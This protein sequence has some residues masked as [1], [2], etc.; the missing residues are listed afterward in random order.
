MARVVW[1]T[2]VLLAMFLIIA[3]AVIVFTDP[4]PST[5]QVEAYGPLEI[6][7]CPLHVT[8]DECWSPTPEPTPTPPVEPALVIVVAVVVALVLS[9]AWEFWR[10]RSSW[11]A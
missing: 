5:V 11:P 10:R 7:V 4:R 8:D 1:R 6:E 2:A 9:A 3:V